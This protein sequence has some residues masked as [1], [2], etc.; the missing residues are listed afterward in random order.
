MRL[1]PAATNGLAPVSVAARVNDLAIDAADDLYLAAGE[2]GLLKTPPDG[3]TQA[4]FAGG[5]MTDGMFTLNAIQSK[6]GDADGGKDDPKD[7]FFA[8]VTK[9]N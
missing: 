5:G 6:A 1:R 4:V 7:G 2:A 3:R 8:V 9:D